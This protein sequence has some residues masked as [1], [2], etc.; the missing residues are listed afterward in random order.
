M[1]RKVRHSTFWCDEQA[2]DYLFSKGDLMKKWA[3]VVL[4]MGCVVCFRQRTGASPPIHCHV[5]SWICVATVRQSYE[6]QA[7]TLLTAGG[8]EI[9]PAFCDLESC[10]IYVLCSN[11]ER[12]Q[13]VLRQDALRHPQNYLP[14]HDKSVVK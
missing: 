5:A 2:I 10:G 9:G 13:R 6:R 11:A 7:M 1:V 8:I 3:A 4:A 12:A 14:L